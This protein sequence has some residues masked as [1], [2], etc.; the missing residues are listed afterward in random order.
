MVNGNKKKRIFSRILFSDLPGLSRISSQ[1]IRK[2]RTQF[3]S[4]IFGYIYLRGVG[5]K[6]IVFKQ[7]MQG[8]EKEQEKSK[9][10]G[11]KEA[12]EEGK[13][14]GKEGMKEGRK[15]GRKEGKRKKRKKRKK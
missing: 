7:V 2:K 3:K 1:E 12:R 9:K 13:E 14:R 8:E 5:F 15:E 4:N 6:C 11:R 10:R